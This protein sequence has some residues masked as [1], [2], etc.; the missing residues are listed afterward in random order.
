MKKV[1]LQKHSLLP[2]IQG[3]QEELTILR[4]EAKL[5]FEKF[6]NGPYFG[7]ANFHLH[8]I[9]EGM[10]NIGNHIIVRIPGAAKSITRYADIADA[11]GRYKIVP[12]KFADDVLRKIARYRNRLVH[13]YAKITPKETYEILRCNLKDIEKFLVYVKRVIKCPEKFNLKISE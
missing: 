5:P 2:R 6:A 9:L 8:N 3:I 4:K 1:P 13:G 10:F 12:K 7:D 11:L